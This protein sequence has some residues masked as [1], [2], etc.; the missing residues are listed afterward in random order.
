MRRERMES[1]AT[2]D[3]GAPSG[4]AA[5][6]SRPLAS[7]AVVP[8][9][10]DSDAAPALQDDAPEL[11]AAHAGQ[12]DGRDCETSGTAVYRASTD[13]LATPPPMRSLHPR[14]QGGGRG[15]A[16]MPSPNLDEDDIFGVLSVLN[17]TPRS[18]QYDAE[19][20]PPPPQAPL[21]PGGASRELRRASGSSGPLQH[22]WIADS[23]PQSSTS[24]QPRPRGQFP[25]LSPQAAPRVAAP[26]V[27]SLDLVAI[28]RQRGAASSRQGLEQQYGRGRELLYSPS[29]RSARQHGADSATAPRAR[30]DGF[31]AAYPPSAALTYSPPF[32]LREVPPHQPQPKV[33]PT[34]HGTSEHRPAIIRSSPLATA[35]PA[36]DLWTVLYGDDA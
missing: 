8:L 35:D 26:N 3:R 34:T 32:S 5:P 12:S 22:A 24:S 30:D 16:V 31:A 7:V 15:G 10:T 21:Q 17:E 2:D 33:N 11:P 9:A 19:P 25:G 36:V 29:M 4:F 20:L 23:S 27:S 13:G 14:L 6:S 18:Q 28:A 1:A